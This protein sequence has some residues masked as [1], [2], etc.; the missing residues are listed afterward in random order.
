MNTCKF[1]VCTVKWLLICTV[2]DIENISS[3]VMLRRECSSMF[4]RS[5]FLIVMFICTF[6]FATVCKG[7]RT[8]VAL[9]AI[10][11]QMYTAQLKFSADFNI[12]PHFE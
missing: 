4:I 3:T 8:I 1:L 5:L 9:V 12:L 2:H 11:S 7:L 6:L 10:I